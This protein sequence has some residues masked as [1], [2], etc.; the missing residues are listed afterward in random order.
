MDTKK[1]GT[2]APARP[3]AAPRLKVYGSVAELTLTATTQQFNK[4]DAS[5]GQNNLT[6]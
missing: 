3:Y 1:F 4:N 2:A 6:T 5:Q